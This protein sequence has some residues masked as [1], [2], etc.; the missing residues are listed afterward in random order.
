[1]LKLYVIGIGYK[2]FS[3]EIR[4]II[5]G[6][7]F[8]LTSERLFDIF[9]ESEEYPKVKE[10]VKVINKVDE[11]FDFIRSKI[12]ENIPVEKN[13]VLLASGDP[14]FYGIGRRAIKELGKEAVEII[15]DLSSIQA[16][17]SKIK[18][19]WDD[20]FLISLHGGPD[21]YKRRNMPYTITDIPLL[22]E[23]HNKIAILTDKENNPSK[24]A[25]ALL[26]SAALSHCRTAALKMFV[27][28]KLGYPD[29][30]ITE[31]LPEDIGKKAYSHPNLVIILNH[32]L[33][34][35]ALS[36]S[37]IPK[38]RDNILFGL[39]E[40]DIIHS[41]GLITK[42]EVRAV[43]LHKLRLMNKGVF[44]DIGAG[45]GSVSL[46]VA[47]LCPEL[48]I[49]AI[50][51]DSQ[52]IQNILSNQ[53]KFRADNIYLIEGQAP[54]ALKE[55]PFPQRVFIGGSGGRLEEIIKF[56]ANISV[57]IVVINAAT[58]ETL[59]KAVTSL[60]EFDY[61]LD[62]VQIHVSRMRKIGEGNYFSALNPVFIIRARKPV[63]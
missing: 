9:R 50:E 23:R 19:S 22:L 20:A 47:R 32:F 12:S 26:E 45:S 60:Q 29:E 49:Y 25:Q 51:K 7:E 34:N 56:I 2:P 4:E 46:E 8:I 14:L 10:K 3:K 41:G 27:C 37:T 18:E 15:P 55:I 35:T 43:T 1:M 11:T 39:S 54:E 53:Q 42:D 17:F 38:G 30:K 57:D 21:P 52:Q 6:S 48:K 36:S 62:V 31:G 44:W 59:N 5:H 33:N 40:D 58:I 24:I 16:A 63:R 61:D 13:I 28:E